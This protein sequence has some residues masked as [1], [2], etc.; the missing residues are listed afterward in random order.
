MTGRKSLAMQ[1]LEAALNVRREMQVG[2]QA[3]V[4]IYDLAEQKGVDVQFR[5]FAGLEGMYSK[6]P[7]PAIL[8]S[9]LR[10]AGR[11][12]YTC[13]HELGHHVFGHGNILVDEFTD[14]SSVQNKRT[15]QEILADLFAGFVL[16]PKYTVDYAFAVR[17]WQAASCTPLQVYTIAGWLG[18]GYT[19]LL[20]HMAKTLQVIPADQA[21]SL[22]KIPLSKL[23]ADYLQRSTKDHLVIIDAQWS[24]RA[25]D[26]SVGDL[27]QLPAEI[28][29]EGDVVHFQED[30]QH[31][32]LF[33]A[34]RQGIGRLFHPT[35]GWAAFVRVSR[36]GYTGLAQYRHQ[37]DPDEN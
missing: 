18:V 22:A 5:P 30:N 14:V 26:V 10:P 37:E 11:Q 12:V 1:A 24:A 3:P 4:C 6:S 19:T 7:G 29:Q 21:R 27:L 23:R 33:C 25:I 35:T 13:A 15:S 17:G 31:G 8:I 16:M 32:R 20:S 9:S 34:V 2:L 36:K 28:Q